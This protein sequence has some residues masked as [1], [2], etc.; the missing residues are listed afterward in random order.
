MFHWQETTMATKK[1]A[2][3]AK[4]ADR[5]PATLKSVQPRTWR[6]MCKLAGDVL[7]A[8]ETGDLKQ[9]KNQLE[10]LRAIATCADA[11]EG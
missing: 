2:K 9:V 11:I 8:L 3:K 1:V 7:L 6:K 5:G 4:P 10:A